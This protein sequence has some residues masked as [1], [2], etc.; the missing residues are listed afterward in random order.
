M[1]EKLNKGQRLNELRLAP[2]LDGTMEKNFERKA[3]F[4]FKWRWRLPFF[5]V[6]K[7]QLYNFAF[8]IADTAVYETAMAHREQARVLPK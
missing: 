3:R 2:L 4:H 5:I 1:V 7:R 6:T 8:N